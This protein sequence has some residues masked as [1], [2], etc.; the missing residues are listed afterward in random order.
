ME[1]Y[2]DQPEPPEHPAIEIL[3]ELKA[4]LQAK[5]HDYAAAEWD[6]NFTG[7]AHLTGQATE[8]VFHMLIGVKVERLRSLLG[9]PG[10][11]DPKNEPVDDTLIDLANYAVLWLT[12][13][14]E[15]REAF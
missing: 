5:A 13:R 2:D 6:D 8:Q 9:T 1:L 14:R 11:G 15:N 12:Y 10:K 4:V 7:T 3:D